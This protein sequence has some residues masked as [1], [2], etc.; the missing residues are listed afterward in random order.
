MHLYQSEIAELRPAYY[1][2]HSE[3]GI[4]E[5]V[6]QRIADDAPIGEMRVPHPPPC[7]CRGAGNQDLPEIEGGSILTIDHH[8]AGGFATGCHLPHIDRLRSVAEG[9]DDSRD[10]GRTFHNGR[11]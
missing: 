5:T 10:C 9:G 6:I 1:A 4:S 8:P 7:R 11:S 2:Y 3:T